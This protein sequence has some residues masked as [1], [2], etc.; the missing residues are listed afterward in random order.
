MYTFCHSL[1]V[2]VQFQKR[3]ITVGRVPC[4]VLFSI[5]N[6]V[7]FTSSWMTSSRPRWRPS[8]F[9]NSKAPVTLAWVPHC[10]WLR[11]QKPTGLS[12]SCSQLA[13]GCLAFSF[14]VYSNGERHS[15]CSS[16]TI[17][18]D[19]RQWK[20][21]PASDWP[22]PL[23]GRLKPL[24]DVVVVSGGEITLSLVVR[25]GILRTVLHMR[26]LKS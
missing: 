24:V 17:G 12:F 13:G 9:V 23:G 6:D 25:F 21:T 7:G 11:T 18:S 22:S 3:W 8:Y 2:F 10:H 26:T 16:P 20:K 4:C 15:K 1:L 14:G 5:A 19:K